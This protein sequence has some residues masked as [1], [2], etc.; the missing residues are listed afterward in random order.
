MSCQETSALLS[1]D[2]QSLHSLTANENFIFFVWCLIILPSKVE[3]NNSP[4][5]RTNKMSVFVD[6]C[7]ELNVMD[8]KYSCKVKVSTFKIILVSVYLQP[9]LKTPL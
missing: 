9:T 1:E 2:D 7:R 4:N 8:H 5:R 3:V 6:K